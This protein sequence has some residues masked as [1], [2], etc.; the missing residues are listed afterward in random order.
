[1]K[2]GF[3]IYS[4]QNESLGFVES[5]E[6]LT[7]KEILSR[8]RNSEDGFFRDGTDRVVKPEEVV[9]C[10]SVLIFCAREASAAGTTSS[11]LAASAASAVIWVRLAGSTA[12]VTLRPG[13]EN[14]HQ[15][16]IHLINTFGL[17]PNG[18][19]ENVQSNQKLQPGNSYKW[20]EEEE[21]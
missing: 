4:D 21:E 1:M 14:A 5:Q 6:P 20:I 16:K 12:R 19:I 13:L 15:V 9:P 2:R 11:T 17:S 10:G 7:A 3:R 18:R 8:F